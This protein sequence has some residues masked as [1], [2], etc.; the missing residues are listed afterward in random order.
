MCLSLINTTAVK[1]RNPHC[2]SQALESWDIKNASARI[3]C[4][5]VHSPIK[6]VTV[7]YEGLGFAS[8]GIWIYN[9][10]K[11]FVQCIL[12]EYCRKETTLLESNKKI[13]L[14]MFPCFIFSNVLLIILIHYSVYA[15]RGPTDTFA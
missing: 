8:F 9:G 7:K 15:K 3:Y 1:F 11:I 10:G 5:D 12:S 6:L 2:C 14:H 13:I 4:R